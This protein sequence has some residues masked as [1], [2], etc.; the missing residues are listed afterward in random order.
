MKKVRLDPEALEVLSFRITEDAEQPPGTVQGHSGY[1]CIETCPFSCRYA[2][3]P[4][5]GLSDCGTC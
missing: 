4:Q 2:C 5:T 3:R 1:T